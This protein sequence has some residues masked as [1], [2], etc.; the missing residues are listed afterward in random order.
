[1]VGDKKDAGLASG[2]EPLDLNAQ[3]AAD[4]RSPFS[5]SDLRHEQAGRAFPV[6]QY[7]VG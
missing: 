4:V 3:R 2:A 1:M 5:A 6:V 7:R